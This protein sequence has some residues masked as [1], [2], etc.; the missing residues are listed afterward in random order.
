MI[1]F[2]ETIINNIITHKIGG[3]NGLSV[4]NTKEFYLDDNEIYD[5]TLKKIFIKPFNSVIETYEFNHHIDVEHNVL[6]KLSRKIYENEN[7]TKI[8]VD[9]HSH[10]QNA[11]KHPN[12]K[13]GDL[14][15]IKYDNLKYMNQYYSGLGIYKIENKENFI[16]TTTNYSDDVSIDFRKGIGSKKPDKACLIIFTEE[17]FTVLILDNAKF[18]TDYWHNDFINVKL[19]NDYINN[20]NQFLN[21]TKSFIT[22]KIPEEYELSKAD[23]IDLL[24]KSVEYFK[25]HDSFEKE[26]FEESVFNDSD[27]INSFRAFDTEYQQVNNIEYENNFEISKQAVKKQA[28]IFK[29][30]LKLDK[31]FHI[32]IHGDK[33]LIESGIDNDGRKYYKIYYEEES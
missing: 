19:K 13:D 3:E 7:F 30:V 25:N 9:I 2:N 23:Q 18:E 11:S 16:E 6:Y 32:Y 4:I 29:S 5:D 10:L 27:V 14:F 20:T 28:R 24:N 12:I 26:E 21:I 33:N 1:D 17:P 22:E 15:I 31:N 8:S